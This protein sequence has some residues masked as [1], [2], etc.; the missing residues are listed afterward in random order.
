MSTIINEKN[1]FPVYD[2]KGKVVG[3][4]P[5]EEE[6]WLTPH[7]DGG[8]G[9]NSNYRL[10]FYT[11]NYDGDDGYTAE[12][13][14]PKVMPQWV[15]TY[16]TFCRQL[17]EIDDLAHQKYPEMYLNVYE[18]ILSNPK[19]KRINKDECPELFV[20]IYECAI[21]YMGKLFKN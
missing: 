8:F 15:K 4:V 19:K 1:A 14:K 21:N 16:N 12:W 20:S 2:A 5:H 10:I 11:L 9:L 17:E 13:D 18:Y 7:E 6:T 3:Y